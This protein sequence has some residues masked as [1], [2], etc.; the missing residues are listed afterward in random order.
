[1]KYNPATLGKPTA[2]LPSAIYNRSMTIIPPSI[3][4]NKRHAIETGIAMSEMSLN[5]KTIGVGEASDFIRPTKP[6]LLMPYM[7][8]SAKVISASENVIVISEVGGRSLKSSRNAL[9]S[10]KEAIVRI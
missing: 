3:F 7:F 1:M 8:I 10:S 9:M 4:P 5:G 6:F 2:L